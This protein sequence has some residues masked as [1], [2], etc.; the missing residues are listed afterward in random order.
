MKKKKISVSLFQCVT[1]SVCHQKKNKKTLTKLFGF[2]LSIMEKMVVVKILT[3]EDGRTKE[4]GKLFSKILMLVICRCLLFI[5]Y[6]GTRPNGSTE[7][8]KLFSKILMTDDYCISF[9]RLSTAVPD[10]NTVREK[11]G[12]QLLVGPSQCARQP[13]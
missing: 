10:T 13:L 11:Y 5:N 6:K 8:G 1:F 12:N 7:D 4:D 3:E 2:G 9:A